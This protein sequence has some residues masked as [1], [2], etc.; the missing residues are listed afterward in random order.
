MYF[1]RSFVF[2]FITFYSYNLY[3]ENQCSPY[4]AKAT[5]NEVNVDKTGNTN[6]SGMIEIKLLDGS[7]T[8][9]TYDDWRVTICTSSNNCND[10]SVADMDD[11]TAPW[12]TKSS[13]FSF[14]LIDFENGFDLSLRDANKDVIDYIQVKSNRDE[15]DNQSVS[16]NNLAYVYPVPS[17][18]NGTKILRRVASDGTGPWDVVNGES[19][20]GTPGSSNDGDAVDVNFSCEATFVDGATS[21]SPTGSINFVNNTYLYQGADTILASPIVNNNGW[22]YS[23]WDGSGACSAS[24][25]PTTA[26]NLPSF[27][28]TNSLSTLTVGIGVPQTIGTSGDNEYGTI[29]LNAGGILN[30]STG[31]GVYKITNLIASG[32]N[33]INLAPGEY[34]VENFSVATATKIYLTEPGEVKF[35][36]KNDLTVGS[37]SEFNKAAASDYQLI[38]VGYGDVTIGGST[39][40]DALIYAQN[41]IVLQGDAHVVGATSGSNV[42]FETSSRINYQCNSVN[43]PIIDHYE[44]I[45]DGVGLTCDAE[46]VT[47]KAC[48]SNIGEE[49][50]LATDENV[51][52]DFVVKDVNGSELSRNR[53]VSF[54]QLGTTSFNH[55]TASDV[56]V[57]IENATPATTDSAI[58]ICENGTSTSCKITFEDVGFVFS[59]IENQYAGVEFD[60]IS[61][62]ALRNNGGVC[63]PILNG[64]VDVDIAVEF[65]NPSAPALPHNAF[66]INTVDIEK[67][68]SG[69][70]TNYTTVS[71][72][73]DADAKTVINNNNYYDAGGLKLHAK[74][75]HPAVD[76][77]SSFEIKGNSN[78]FRVSPYRFDIKAVNTD[79]IELTATTDDGSPTHSARKPFTLTANAVNFQGD[80]TT[81]YQT[82]MGFL[83]VTRTGPTSEG[84]DGWLKIS[85]SWFGYATSRVNWSYFP[86]W[87]WV[88]FVD[89]VYQYESN[90]S[91]VGL[92]NVAIQQITY[93]LK[94]E[95]DSGIGRFVP[96]HFTLT[97]N[98]VDNSCNATNITYM[99]E[100][101]LTLTYEIEARSYTDPITEVST[102]TKNYLEN[103]TENYIHST[104][105]F[106]A[107][108]NADGIDLGSRLS[109]Y[110]G[111]WV[112]GIFSPTPEPTP[113][114]NEDVGSFSRA[115]TLDGPYDE[116]RFG[117]KLIDDD[118]SLL[119]SLNM[120]SADGSFS[121]ITLSDTASK[122]R[123][124]RWI[125]E[126][127][128][129]GE[130]SVLPQI[131]QAQYYNGSSFV[132]N[133]LDN[134][135]TI[136]GGI[137]NGNKVTTGSLHDSLPNPWDYRLIQLESPVDVED[138]FAE[139]S[140]IVNQFEAGIHR[141]T[142]F[143]APGKVGDLQ[144]QLS[145]PAWLKYDWQNQ[146]NGTYDDNPF[147]TLSF[148]IYRGNDRIISWREVNN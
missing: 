49:C 105:T 99:G 132:T 144:W 50:L 76:G 16:C 31:Q 147:A 106:V 100:P 48:T 95:G 17:T 18:Q 58:F 116:L 122:L 27:D 108:N 82:S 42:S 1:I 2:L 24:G 26:I 114:Y 135:T 113:D 118:G 22:G 73:F 40:I 45:H 138:S 46:T 143:T 72:S 136:D 133:K 134:C 28:T 63:Q 148:G 7:L 140:G 117:L 68:N 96:D 75:I 20:N 87:Y 39:R 19:E 15:N 10:F 107:E 141:G 104:I 137:N 30:T 78:E 128:S 47:I 3:A 102:L 110:Q 55:T 23:C 35:Y 53:G 12:L 60:G 25:T 14:S 85:D 80:I 36:V 61:V 44:I 93:G 70:V 54:N 131:M 92:I 57:S 111:E 145:V 66:E 101:K 34:W 43:T 119:E 142:Q 103:D 81:N 146:N 8:S 109:G 69:S 33:T 125:I 83:K 9:S 37:S 56:Y 64:N 6:S 11:T 65:S 91:E 52:L 4:I 62:Q 32:F 13:G 112:S 97:A 123:F 67:N 79:G 98:M 71:L 84:V 139:M 74:Y 129:G 29:T 121:A 127:S 77:E 130:N 41:N 94:T 86:F 38:L 120:L 124:G 5:I 51:V 89:G 21:H 126:N 90:Y 59:A 88:S 115:T